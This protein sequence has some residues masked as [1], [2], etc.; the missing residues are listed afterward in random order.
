MS[1]MRFRIRIINSRYLEII[2][3]IA[4]ICLF[5]ILVIAYYPDADLIFALSDM[6][7]VKTIGSTSFSLL[8]VT[9]FIGLFVKIFYRKFHS[10]TILVFS[11]AAGIICISDQS[12][13]IFISL[14]AYDWQLPSVFLV[15]HLQIL[16]ILIMFII[17]AMLLFRPH[18]NHDDV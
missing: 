18:H 12:Y 1:S 14:K 11:I 10:I 6:A 15:P 16:I 3:L 8:S 4:L 13:R 9:L 5:A 7:S 2:V 17:F